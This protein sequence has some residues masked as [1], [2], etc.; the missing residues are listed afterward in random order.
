M[1]DSHSGGYSAAIPIE[2]L[3]RL[4]RADCNTSNGCTK[5]GIRERAETVVRAKLCPCAST[6]DSIVDA[7]VDEYVRQLGTEK[8]SFVEKVE[9][10]YQLFSIRLLLAE[11]SRNN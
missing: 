1:T 11:S 7:V 9:P 2:E 3:T 4:A 5:K 8:N 10:S 6:V